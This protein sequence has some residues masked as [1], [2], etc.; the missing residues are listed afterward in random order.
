MRGMHV[1][2]GVHVGYTD[3]VCNGVAMMLQVMH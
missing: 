3:V 2:H 1:G